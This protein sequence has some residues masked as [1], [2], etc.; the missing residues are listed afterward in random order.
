MFRINLN[1][2][3]FFC[4]TEST[5]VQ[6]ARQQMVKVPYA[7][8]GGGCGYCKVRVTE[9]KYKMDRYAKSALSDEE[10]E[11]GYVLLCKTRPL[12]DLQIELI[13]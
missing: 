6:A 1:D 9:G 7:C 12:S 13:M 8:V 2:Q 3:H 4:S 5:L 10:V 11:K